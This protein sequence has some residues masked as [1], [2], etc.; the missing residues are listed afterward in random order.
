LLHP[1]RPDVL[2]MQGTWADLDDRQIRP[3]I[4][5]LLLYVSL[6]SGLWMEDVLD[7]SWGWR[8][9]GRNVADAAPTLAPRVASH[10]PCTAVRGECAG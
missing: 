7:V 2:G 3:R 9:P 10:A 5:H 8:D 1:P 4:R 6:S